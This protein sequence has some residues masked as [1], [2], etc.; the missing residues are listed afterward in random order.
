MVLCRYTWL[1]ANVYGSVSIYMALCQYTWLCVNI[2]GSVRM[3]MALCQYTWLCAN[4]H[5]SVPNHVT[6]ILKK[7]RFQ[8]QQTLA[9]CKAMTLRKRRASGRRQYGRPCMHF[10][11]GALRMF[12][13]GNISRFLVCHIILNYGVVI[14][15]NAERYLILPQQ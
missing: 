6:V 1:C 9:L 4:V 12:L 14:R 8:K 2:R 3:Y 13:R 11:R 7:V 15:V 10:V 5:G